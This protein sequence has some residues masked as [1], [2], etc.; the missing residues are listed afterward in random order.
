MWRGK[1]Y[2]SSSC[3]VVVA[4]HAAARFEAGAV[5]TGASA[6]EVLAHIERLR[7]YGGMYMFGEEM[8]SKL[9][10]KGRLPSCHQ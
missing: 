5:V 3:V 2:A 7:L 6:A 8:V 1:V 10:S 9:I 4:A